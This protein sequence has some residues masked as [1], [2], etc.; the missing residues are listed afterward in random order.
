MFLDSPRRLPL[1]FRRSPLSKLGTRLL[2]EKSAQAFATAQRPLPEES[3]L[4]RT[5]FL[6]YRFSVYPTPL[7]SRVVEDIP[8]RRFLFR[9]CYP[10]RCTRCSASR[11]HRPSQV[12]D[13]CPCRAP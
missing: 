11:R 1:S 6:P 9:A 4:S 13:R 8:R 10:P 3:I 12:R 7:A 5:V 2:Q